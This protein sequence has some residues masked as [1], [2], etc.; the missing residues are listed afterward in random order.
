MSWEKRLRE[1]FG[2]LQ[3][4]SC[5]R[6]SDLKAFISREIARARAEA[7]EEYSRKVIERYGD[8]DC[9]DSVLII[10]DEERKAALEKFGVEGGK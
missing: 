2:I 5:I 4:M 6:Y 8:L 1:Q 9:T 10:M 7:F 3:V